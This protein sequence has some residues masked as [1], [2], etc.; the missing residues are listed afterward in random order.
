MQQGEPEL[1]LLEIG[2]ERKNLLIHF[3]RLVKS[4][5]LLIQKALAVESQGFG[6]RVGGRSG[7]L[8][9]VDVHLYGLAARRQQPAEG[10][11]GD[12]GALSLMYVH[13]DGVSR[14]ARQF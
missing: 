6:T 11:G 1:K 9:P 7:V 10:H 5:L 13:G 3:Y 8:P 12:G 4:L 2:I 14:H